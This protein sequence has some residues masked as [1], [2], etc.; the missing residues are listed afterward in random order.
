MSLPLDVRSG[1][2][3]ASPEPLLPP[4]PDVPGWPIRTPS[5]TS[6]VNGAALDRDMAEFARAPIKL[7]YVTRPSGVGG[8]EKSN[9]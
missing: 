9:S 4:L 3:G 7:D 5:V 2:Q 1:V 8:P 6:A